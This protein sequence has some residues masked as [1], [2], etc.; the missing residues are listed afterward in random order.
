MSSSPTQLRKA[1][2]QCPRGPKTQLPTPLQEIG[3]KC[4]PRLLGVGRTS[5][6]EP[7]NK[8]TSGGKARPSPQTVWPSAEEQRASR[9]R[10][11][12][13]PPPAMRKGCFLA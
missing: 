6:R 1:S 10:P 3:M 5:R 11:R 4:C 2:Q 8:T 9:Q 7:K 13:W 12:H